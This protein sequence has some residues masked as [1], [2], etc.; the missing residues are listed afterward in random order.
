VDS[1]PRS[2]DVSK[3]LLVGMRNGS[4]AEYDIQK[5]AKEVIMHSHCEGEVWGLT[6]IEGGV[7]KF[8]SSGDDNQIFMFDLQQK[9]CILKGNVVP[10]ADNEGE[11]EEEK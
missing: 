4:I 8:F 11:G 1:I 6:A 3:Y 10:V 7:N 5:N 9:K 2:V